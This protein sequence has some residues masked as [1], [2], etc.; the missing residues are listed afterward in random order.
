MELKTIR[1]LALLCCL[2]CGS[3]PP[4]RHSDMGNAVKPVK[5]SIKTAPRVGE[6]IDD[7]NGIPVYY[8]GTVRQV[9]GRHEH[10]NGYNYGL[11]W[12]CV[13]FVKRYYY[14]YL[15]HSMPNTWGHA[16]EFF[17]LYLAN[18]IFNADRGLYQFRNG[19]RRRPMI[20]DILVFG[21]DQ[22]GHVAIISAVDEGHIEIV[23]QNVGPYSRELIN[24]SN[25]DG[26]WYVRHS[27]V[28]GW[29]SL[30][31]EK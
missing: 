12:Q 2:S 1:L 11:R 16:R 15:E 13:E 27:K 29:L 5:A 6:Q 22:F 8:N 31:G 4:L 9:H 7:L 10:S 20:D 24:L 23:Q 30:F 28:L 21:G 18:G 17:N 19:S 3:E 25:R 26:R 14:D